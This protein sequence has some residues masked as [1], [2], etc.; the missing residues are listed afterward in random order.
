MKYEDLSPGDSLPDRTVE[1]VDAT[2]MKLIAAILQDP[3]PVHYDPQA[4][5][6][7]GF[8]GRLNQGPAN[9]SY[10]FQCVYDVLA[11]PGDLR[12]F[13]S[14]YHDMVFE[15]ETVTASATVADKRIEDGDGLVT[16]EVTL[17]KED[18]SVAVDGTVTARL[19]R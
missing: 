19:P 15:D 5:S 7:L 4:S 12:S 10:I 2:D 6:A 17:T 13:E 18:G 8:P 11:S 9:L 3:Y 14:S 1:D 16:F